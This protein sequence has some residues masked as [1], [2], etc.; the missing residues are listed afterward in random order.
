MNILKTY[1]A[2]RD[3]QRVHGGVIH[4]GEAFPAAEVT[5]ALIDTGRVTGGAGSLP[6][7][8]RTH[9]AFTVAEL[10]A[11]QEASP[12]VT[13]DPGVRCDRC[14]EVDAE[15]TKGRR[16]EAERRADEE[17]EIRERNRQEQ[18]QLN[19]E[20]AQRER[21]EALDGLIDEALAKKQAAPSE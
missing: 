16:L 13:V 20:R 19:A 15:W 1:H 2:T 3:G 7:D 10:A 9:C 5:R 11:L 17:R 21:Q 8:V 14:L 4:G 6:A 18:T 12:E